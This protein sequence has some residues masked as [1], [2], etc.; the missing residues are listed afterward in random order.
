MP[1]LAA[2]PHRRLQAGPSWSDDVRPI[3]AEHCFECH[4]PD[5]GT[6]R[7]GLRLAP[8]RACSA[9][10]EAREPWTGGTP[11]SELLLRVTSKD[12][13]DRMPPPEAGSASTRMTSPFFSDGSMLERSGSRTGH[14]ARSR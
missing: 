3:L 5:E 14:M 12:D 9:P 4:G 10:T 13:F 11:L 1:S 2:A 8:R 7:A 6:R